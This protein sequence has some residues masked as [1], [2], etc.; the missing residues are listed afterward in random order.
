VNGKIQPHHLTRLAVV[1]VRQSS[2]TQTRNNLESPERQRALAKRGEELG[3][4]PTQVLVIEEGRARSGSSTEGRSDYRRVCELIAK[5]QVGI[6]LAV[7]VSRWARD[8][9]VWQWLLRDCIFENV[10][11]GDEHQVYD[12]N[13]SHDHVMLGIQGVL[14]EHELRRIRE[15]TIEC[16][17]SKARRHEMFPAIP[18]GMV[19]V[20]GKLEK[21][22]NRRV[23]RSLERLFAKFNECCSVVELCRWY[24]THKE[25]LPYVAHGDDPQHVRWQSPS[26]KRLLITLKN[27]TYAGAYVIGRKQTIQVRNEHGEI[28][29][30]R[31][32][33]NREQWKVVQRE[34]FEGYITWQQYEANMA[35]IQRNARQTKSA[36]VAR[37]GISLLSGLLRCARCGSSFH[38]HYHRSHPSYVCRGGARQRERGKAC[39]TF[40]G[41]TAEWLFSEMVMEAVRPAALVASREAAIQMRAHLQQDRQ[42]LLDQL[43]QLEYETDRARRQ[44]DLVEPENRLVAATL[45]RRWNEA[46]QSANAQ[47]A[48][49]DQFDK[50]HSVPSG[51]SLEFWF[52]PNRLEEVWRCESSDASL[53][54]QIVDLLVREVVVEPS[55][56]GDKVQLW[57]HWQGGHHTQVMAPRRARSGVSQRSEAKQLISALSCVSDDASIARAL[58]RNGIEMPKTKSDRISNWT[59][60]S[61][62]QFRDRHAIAAFDATEKLRRGLLTG[63]EASRRLGVSAMSIHRLVAAG[64]LPAEQIRS[65]LPC[66]IE[67]IALE[68]P[69]VQQAA[70]R[71]QCNLRRPLTDNSSQ[72][73]L[74]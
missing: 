68:L 37:R 1:Y 6:I 31:R 25:L 59:A 72:H 41:R 53:K 36:G 61:V 13:D 63:E 69:E 55:E 42:V 57:I 64:I 28:V 32:D 39:L 18:T 43:A 5:Q 12:P 67:A 51:E 22:P 30:R 3:W 52:E 27:P 16:W 14:A 54:K 24:L 48:R 49:L 29:R 44:F 15:R 58:N 71:I 70:Q 35:K 46:L 11:L 19:L 10:L 56:S 66:I 23:R 60:K 4:P 62:K 33:V 17:W 20:E 47:R 73:K 9:V 2:P 50:E 65:G 8:N 38:V 26:Y 74:F 21:H 45:E 40:S 7:D 34:H